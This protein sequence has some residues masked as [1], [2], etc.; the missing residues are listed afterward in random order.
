MTQRNIPGQTESLLNRS[1]QKSLGPN[2]WVCCLVGSMKGFQHINSG[3]TG[4]C[5]HICPELGETGSP[6][7]HSVLCSELVLG[8]R[9][10]HNNSA[11][12][13]LVPVLESP[14]LEFIHNWCDWQLINS[15]FNHRFQLPGTQKSF[16]RTAPAK[17]T[18][19]SPKPCGYWKRCPEFPV[20]ATRRGPSQ[21]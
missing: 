4:L 6:A 16:Q 9:S 11:D 7:G 5:L 3:K 14:R 20:G 8:G 17:N 15:T 18:L 1:L 19:R 2:P 10:V 21:P 13:V 12:P